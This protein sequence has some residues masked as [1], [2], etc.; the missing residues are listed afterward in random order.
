LVNHPPQLESST[1]GFR[2]QQQP[3][4]RIEFVGP[5]LD[6][7]CPADAGVAEAVPDHAGLLVIGDSIGAPSWVGS[8]LA[9]LNS[10]GAVPVVLDRGLPPGGAEAIITNAHRIVRLHK[11]EIAV[12]LRFGQIR[13]EPWLAP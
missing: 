3:R 11:V 12:A 10:S 6:G 5:D 4:T 2:G 1:G 8:G 7:R 9:D 13:K